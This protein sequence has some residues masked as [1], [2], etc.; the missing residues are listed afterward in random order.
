M[1]TP[2]RENYT[3]EERNYLLELIKERSSIIENC[4]NTPS[5]N[6]KKNK[7]WKD[8][9]AIFNNNFPT[10]PPVDVNKL[11]TLYRRLK[12]EAKKEHFAHKKARRKTGGGPAPPEPSSEAKTL[13]ELCPNITFELNNSYDCDQSTEF[14]GNQDENQPQTSEEGEEKPEEEEIMDASIHESE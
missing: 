14:T 9:V 11:R 10:K 3:S 12:T 8:I 6:L 2:K 4:Q 7:C 13:M 5:V 1:N